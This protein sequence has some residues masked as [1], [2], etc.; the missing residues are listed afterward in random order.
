MAKASQRR[1]K[2]AQP[3]ARKPRTGGGSGGGGSKHIR[4]GSRHVAETEMFFPRLRKQAKWMFILLAVVF[5]VGFV[6]FGVGSGSTGIGDLFNG[7]FFGL[8]GSGGG[9]GGPSV[10]NAQ[11]EVALHPQRAQAYLDLANAYQAK[12]DNAGAISALGRYTQLRPK[13][14]DQ[15]RKLAG[16]Y[17]SDATAAQQAAQQA[18]LD[19]PTA[20]S[21]PLFQ[22]SGPLGQALGTDPIQSALSTQVNSAF[23]AAVTQMQTAEQNAIGVYKQL[24]KAAPNDPTT[25]FDLAQAA[26]SAQDLPTAIAAYKKV[27]AL[28]P[29]SSDVPAIKQHLKQLQASA[30]GS[31][32]KSG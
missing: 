21:A 13:D 4:G 19:N 27:I 31:T 18:Q 14:Q 22:P 28:E 30:V 16:L 17:M 25:F 29:D 5:A 24:T 12:N 9:S 7:K 3:H 6:G 11:K 23:Q 32:P 8:G 10:S 15:L 2:R 20:V 1:R 26:E